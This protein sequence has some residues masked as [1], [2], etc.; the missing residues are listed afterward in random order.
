M[1]KKSKEELIAEASKL[2]IDVAGKTVKQLE[3]A[4]AKSTAAGA[5]AQEGK[6]GGAAPKKGATVV[7]VVG[8]E[9]V[10]R[11]YSQEE[12]GKK[13]LEYADEFAGKVEGRKVVAHVE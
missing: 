7:D 4:I 5:D 3:T 1:A 2:G 9:G 11:T 13:F 6:V 12:H 8:P 10:I